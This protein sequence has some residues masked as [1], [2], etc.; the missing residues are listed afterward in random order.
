MRL[1]LAPVNEASIY[2]D[3]LEQI[4]M[5]VTGFKAVGSVLSL[6][7]EL[8]VSKYVARTWQVYPHCFRLCYTPTLN[9]SQQPRFDAVSGQTIV[10]HLGT[11]SCEA[12]V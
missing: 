12:L 7:D 9:I 4:V 11:L 10:L 2:D 8:V 6:R 5:R 1:G 3:W